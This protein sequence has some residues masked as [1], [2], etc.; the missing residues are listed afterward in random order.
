M[1]QPGPVARSD[2][3]PTGI[4]HVV[5]RSPCPATFFRED[6][7]TATLSLPRIQKLFKSGSCLS[8]TKGCAQ[9]TG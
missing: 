9:S 7:S 2:A 4:Q 3:R 5:D 6:I 8:L 1:I